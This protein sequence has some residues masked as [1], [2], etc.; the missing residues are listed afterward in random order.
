MLRSGSICLSFMY[1]Y[2]LSDSEYKDPDSGM[3]LNKKSHKLRC[4]SDTFQSYG[5]V[6]SKLSQMLSFN[7]SSSD[8]FSD[9]KPFSREETIKF[10]TDQLMYNKDFFKNIHSI[11]MEVYKSGSVGQVHLAKYID[12]TDIILKI[13][14]QGLREQTKADLQML[15]IITTYLYHFSDIKTAMVDIKTKLYEELD[16]IKE[17]S[18]QLLVADLWKD[19]DYVE[20]PELIQE[21]CTDNIICMKYIQGRS[22][23]NFISNSTQEERNKLGECIVR[24]T[25]E[26][27]YKHKILYSDVHY[28]NFLVK[29]N[30]TLCVLDFGCLTLIEPEMCKL[31]HRLYL[32]LLDK[33]KEI[34]YSTV[35]ELGIIK[36][37][38]SAESKDY[39]YSYFQYQYQ[40]W[41]SSEFEFTEEWLDKSTDKDLELMKEWILPQGMVHFNKIPYG[42]YHLLTKLG[43][44]GNFLHIFSELIPRLDK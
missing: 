21:I 40:P 42:C 12:N 6:L 1:N 24:F 26:N 35:E 30:S 39:I 37:D 36:S 5:G 15:D 20:I 38:I 17:V 27:I 44:K 32:S 14:Y 31:L 23:T 11:D 29:D 9:C 33:D 10:L 19:C 13:Q 43:L 18:N 28:G 2:L 8:V 34:F 7:D 16:Y 3:T 22:I 25:F 4:L 41:I